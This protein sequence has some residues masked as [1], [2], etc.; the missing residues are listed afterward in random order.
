[1]NGAQHLMNT[2]IFIYFTLVFLCFYKIA[3]TQS[4]K[5]SVQTA[6]ENN[7][8]LKSQRVLLDNSY[9]NYLIQN[10]TTL[11]NLSLSGTGTRS[12]NFDSNQ[13]L[14]SYSIS[15]NSSYVLFD[16]GSQNANKR[17]ALILNDASKLSFKKFENDVILNVVKV[18]LELF[19]AIKIVEL[20]ENSLEI[21]KQQ[22][23][24]V[25]NRFELGEATRS[26]LLRAKASISAAKAQLKVGKASVEKFRERYKTLVG[27]S[28]T[29]P[30]LPK[31]TTKEPVILSES[32]KVGLEND[33]TLKILKLEEQALKEEL[34]STE[35]SRLPN[36]SLSRALSYGDSQ[37]LGKNISSGRISLTSNLSLYSG[38]QKKAQVK[39][40]SNKLA[41]K[42][43]DIAVRKNLLKQN[44]TTKWLDLD[45]LSSS[46]TAK[47]EETDALN[48]LYESIFE[49]W[50]LGGKTSLDTDQAY[51]NFLNSEVELVTT[52][53]D[54]LIAKFDL[55]AEIGT[56]RT[57][58][59]LR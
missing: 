31:M 18:H 36:L 7:E 1:M 29:S 23:F 16:F 4:I 42:V 12:S 43:I 56:L 40:A 48:E 57:G 51:Q 19:K 21:R 20:F 35:K 32:I 33:L 24:A 11:P 8:G 15:L 28:P 59:Q 30:L 2:K 10:G 3:F 14:D 25:K 27:K 37:S 58:L 52:T 5:Q 17:S 9:Q 54:I 6:L 47:Q 34:N 38:G 45:A 13:D 26:D 55:L 39:I 53:T 41:A 50:K 46:E 49:E 44:V 22:F